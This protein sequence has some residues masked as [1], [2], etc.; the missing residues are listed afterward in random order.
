MLYYSLLTSTCSLLL[1]DLQVLDYA[2][3][4]RVI[5]HVM[6]LYG[7][8][9]MHPHD[10]SMGYA[11]TLLFIDIFASVLW[12]FLS[13]LFQYLLV[14][15]TMFRIAPDLMSDS[16]MVLIL[17]SYRTILASSLHMPLTHPSMVNM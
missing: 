14:R 5:Q 12:F 11:S 2:V 15:S 4:F 13:G 10:A 1:C 3:G 7:L 6:S 16:C 8:V 9:A 17:A